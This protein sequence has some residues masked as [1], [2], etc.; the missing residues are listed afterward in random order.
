M[1]QEG[2]NIRYKIYFFKLVVYEGVIK[3]VFEI[4]NLVNL[5]VELGL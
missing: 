3:R 1:C 2:G 5:K 4:I